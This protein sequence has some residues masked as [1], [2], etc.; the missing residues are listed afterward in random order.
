[1][2]RI[3]KNFDSVKD[4]DLRLCLHRGVAYQADMSKK[5]KYDENYFES[6]ERYKKYPERAKAILEIR[7]DIVYRHSGSDE[8]LDIGIGDGSFV[9]SRKNTFGYD[10]NPNAEKWL[11]SRKLWSND[12]RSFDAFT[13]WDTLE[14]IEEP[15]QYLK[16]V[17]KHGDVFVSIPIFENLKDIRQS[18]HYRPGEHLY[19]FTHQGFVDWM[20]AY[21]FRLREW[22]DLETQ[23]GR[24]SINTYAFKKDAPQYV[25]NVTQY[26]NIYANVYG[27][28]SIVYFDL[29]AAE[30]KKR[31]PK[32]I[33][34]Y[35]CGWSEIVC[36]FWKDG[37]R[38]IDRFDPAIPRFKERPDRRFDFTICTDV[39]EHIGMS[40][41]DRTLAD[42][43]SLSSNVFFIIS[44]EKAQTILPDGRNAHITL[45]TPSEWQRWI[46]SYFEHAEIV[47]APHKGVIVVKTYKS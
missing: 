14:H 19:Y 37:E 28:S 47:K 6:L 16:R 31:N 45:L 40:D 8:V 42:I 18:R 29:I 43:K 20:S 39:L 36:W 12:F 25:E 44:I 10:I 1:M 27:N 24:N 13:F 41:I 11:K 33:L 7:N 17:P 9:Q 21:G 35:G 23:A 4:D 2:D 38:V 30:V 26:K 22:H 3:I 46:K 32:S 5:I 15:E 34:D